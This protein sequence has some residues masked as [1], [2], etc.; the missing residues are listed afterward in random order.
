[1]DPSVMNSMMDMMKNPQ[2][3]NHMNE[4]MKNPKIQEMMN[5]PELINGMMNMFGDNLPPGMNLHDNGEDANNKPESSDE[6][7][8]LLGDR[9]FSPEDIVL[10]K[11]LKNESF[12]GRTGAIVSYNEEKARYLVQLDNLDDTPEELRD[13]RIMVKEENLQR[14]PEPA[15]AEETEE[16]EAII[17]ID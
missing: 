3:M 12:N 15:E 2:L 1:M 4:M 5:S 10:L 7:L 17:N 11:K 6:N 13:Q 8:E 14:E 16:T 9:Q